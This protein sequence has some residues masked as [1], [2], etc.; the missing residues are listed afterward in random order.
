M[1]N[2]LCQDLEKL[3][4]KNQ[5]LDGDIIRAF[6]KDDM[7]YNEQDRKDN[8]KRIAFVS[9]LLADNG[10]TVIVAAV[11]SIERDFLRKRRR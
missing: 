3:N 4:I 11:S 6:F 5:L 10:I 9:K 2:L 1:A 7:G 8:L